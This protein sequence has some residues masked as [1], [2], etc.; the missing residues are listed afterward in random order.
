MDGAAAAEAPLLRTDEGGVALLRLNRPAA[1]N[2]LSVSLLDALAQALAAIAADRAV[3]A[4]VLA[5][6]G[7]AFCAGHDLRE[8]TAAR[9]APD[10]GAAFFADT[11]ARCSA[12]M[13]A[14]A[15]LPQPVIAAVRGMATAAGC[16]L[17]AT[18]DLAVAGERAAFCTP[19]VSIGLF[20]STPAVALT[21]AVPPKAAMEML[22]TG[23][24]IGAEEAR[25]IFLVNRVVPD[26]EEEAEARRIARGIAARSAAVVRLG[27]RALR[28]QEGLG[29]A[30][31]YARAS[32]AMVENLLC[33]D[34]AEG[35]SAFL[36]KRA[37]VWEDR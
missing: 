6:N 15:T 28:E 11:M 10:G 19:G 7:P 8:L 14:I 25:R 35:I 32:A 16:Q 4:V 18:C 26:G 31:A 22:L 3:R 30:E 23:E 34:A 20:C 13:Q 27:K 2:A 5:A 21:R 36:A 1:R 9:E 12:V 33:R 29:L 37:P 17:V 24:A